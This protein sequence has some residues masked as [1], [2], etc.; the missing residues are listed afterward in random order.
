MVFRVRP[1]VAAMAVVFPG[2][3]PAGAQAAPPDARVL[4]APAVVVTAERMQE[5]LTV[6]TDPKAPRQPIPAHD[7]ADYLKTIPGF[8]VIRKG[9]TDGDPVLR[10]M[11]GSRL[12]ILLD[13]QQILGG[14]GQR[15]D[16]PT[17][18]VFPESYDRVTVL[19][20]PQTV[21][22]GPGNSAGTV[23]FERSIKRWERP[24]WKF[25]GSLTAGSFGRND[26]VVDVRGGTPDFYAQ[27]TATRSDSDD[28]RDGAGNK[29]HSAYTRWSTGA[30]FGW[31][32]DDRTR[33]ELSGLRSDGHAAYADRTMDGVKFDREN[34][35]LKFETRAVSERI[36][37]IEAQA[38]YN[39]VDHV[40]DNY[41]LRVRPAG[42]GFMV[43]NPDRRTT[44]ARIAVGLRPVDALRLTV[45]VDLQQNIHTI[46]SAGSMMAAPDV[47]ALGRV[48]DANFRNAGVFGEATWLFAE[49][50]RVVGGLR[51]DD[52][53]AQDM[54]SALALGTGMM[55][56]TVANPTAGQT[57][58]E[59]LTSAFARYE[60]DLADRSTVYAGI[61]RSSRFP[62]YWELFTTGREGADGVSAFGTKPEKNTQLDVGWIGQAGP[63]S[64]SVSG[65]YSNVN[66]FILI[67]SNVVR[68]TP[69]RTVSVTRN[70]DA[71][72]YGGEVGAAWPFARNWKAEGSLAMVRGTNETDGTPLAQL[73][74]YE[75]RAGVHWKDGTWS[76]GSLLRVA[77]AQTRVDP[78]KGNIVGQDIGPT[79]GFAVF[80]MNV[81]YTPRKDVLVTAGVDNLFDRKYAEH[82]SR[83]GAAVAGFTQ[84]ARVNEPGRVLWI[85]ARFTFD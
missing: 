5:P 61:G 26:Q 62:D 27:G 18:Y 36:E 44:G 76:A 14:C 15:M 35:G 34:I 7:G 28:Y 80:S 58:N 68:T 55:A 69:N 46:R 24:G 33:L 79:G 17:A 1:L 52:W 70:V 39:Y 59:T 48:E 11:A 64:L 63:V 19:K 81:G 6:V 45:G 41:S 29:V 3:L 9:G 21:L 57:R 10:G 32:P 56:P 37:K 47:G 54:R 20:G 49:S 75:A 40:M 43:S 4:T 2:V 50:A 85:R 38:Y 67:H 53:R 65:F 12:A 60:R 42:T 74:P 71:H 23:L 84:T 51:M 72:T 30:A 13:G 77:A 8:S 82:I 83:A 78:N 31:T 73:P 25:D 66:D 22:Y 16:P